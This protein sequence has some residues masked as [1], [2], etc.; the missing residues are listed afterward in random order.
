MQ[1]QEELRERVSAARPNMSIAYV[2]RGLTTFRT[3]RIWAN[4]QERLDRFLGLSHQVSSLH[5]S[6]LTVRFVTRDS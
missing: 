1:Q 2:R 4:Y 5:R 6:K 3:S